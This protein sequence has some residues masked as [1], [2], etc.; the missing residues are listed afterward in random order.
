MI[1]PSNQ[2]RSQRVCALVLP[3]LE[4]YSSCVGRF[5]RPT[6]AVGS[7]TCS[8]CT[9]RHVLHFGVARCKFAVVLIEPCPCGEVVI[10]T[11]AR[12]VAAAVEVFVLVVVA[13]QDKRNLSSAISTTSAYPIVFQPPRPTY[14]SNLI[15]V[16]FSTL[17]FLA[18]WRR[19]ALL[20]FAA[21]L[22]F[23]LLGVVLS[24]GPLAAAP[25]HAGFSIEGADGCGA[26]FAR[27][28]SVRT[29]AYFLR[30]RW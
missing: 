28:R 29:C 10:V 19:S 25:R 6:I 30:C 7:W 18:A 1:P 21:K 15:F 11:T 3:L 27:T 13:V 12:L 4:D 14:S 26:Y 24:S 9:I 22:I 16:S 23:H 8:A 20:R 5:R 17:H 2:R